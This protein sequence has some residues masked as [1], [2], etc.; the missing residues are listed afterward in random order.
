MQL[1]R[2]IW[3][4]MSYFDGEL[5]GS[6]VALIVAMIALMV[7]TTRNLIAGIEFDFLIYSLT[8]G[9]ILIGGSAS[10]S[11]G[12]QTKRELKE[13]RNRL[14]ELESRESL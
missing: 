11:S 3:R 6:A 5:D 14:A 12:R 2:K 4:D 13:L 1:L 9:V 10:I 7:S 8:F